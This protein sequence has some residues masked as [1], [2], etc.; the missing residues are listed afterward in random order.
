MVTKYNPINQYTILKLLCNGPVI[1]A[2]RNTEDFRFALTGTD[3]PGIIILFGD[4]NTLPGL[5]SEAQKAK[6]RLIVHVD[7]L[8]GVGKDKAGINFLAR[9][10]VT[11][12]ITTKP[13]LIKY[14]HEEGMIAIQRLF[15]VDSEALRTGIHMIRGCRPDAV[16][17]LPASIPAT[18]VRCLEEQ[19]GL[20]ILAGGLLNTRDD[21]FSAMRHGLA[22]VS[23]S[24]C[25]LW[26]CKV[27]IPSIN[28]KKR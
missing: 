22:A 13:H 10:G 14:V 23:A 17:V 4:I 11:A 8:E 2:P 25:E 20:P 6:K 27:D 3:A 24:R 1:P 7:L 28:V 5:L 26:N 12:V 18:V 21:I 19:T 16:E 15:L 9:L